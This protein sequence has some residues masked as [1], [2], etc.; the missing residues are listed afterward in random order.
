MLA[1]DVLT[2]PASHSLLLTPRAR[3]QTTTVATLLATDG[4]LVDELCD[5]LGD[6]P[7]ALALAAAYLEAHPGRPL[8]DYLAE[9][10]TRVL[11]HDSLDD[12]PLARALATAY[13]E[14]HPGRTLGDYLAEVRTQVLAHDSFDATLEEPLPPAHAPSIVATLALS[15]NQLVG[16]TPSD[17]FALTLLHHV[18]HAAATP[19]PRALL[20]AVVD[21]DPADPGANRILDTALRRLASLGLVDPL[22]DGSARLHR[23]LAAYARSRAL[24]PGADAAALETTLIAVAYQL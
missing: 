16:T 2:R 7:L 22:P 14:A 8:S 3:R 18:A 9:I 23:L 5:E 4:P 17:T 6:F 21:L 13:L 1:L 20:L 15:Y 10:R 12:F 19:I 24:D 11:A